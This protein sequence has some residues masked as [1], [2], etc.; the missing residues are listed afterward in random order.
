[1]TT[2]NT[3]TDF[4]ERHLLIGKARHLAKAQIRQMIDLLSVAFAS[5]ARTGE[6]ALSK[7]LRREAALRRAD[8]LLR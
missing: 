7:S 5:R 1:M 3:N 2:L 8:T 6:D 4:D